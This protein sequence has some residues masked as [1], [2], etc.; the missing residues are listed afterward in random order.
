[1]I[2]EKLL[3]IQQDLK[4]PKDLYNSFGNYS[5]R[6]CESILEALKPLLKANGCVITFSDKMIEVGG[7]NYAE[8]TLK[9]IDAKSG[10]TI[11]VTACAREEETKK[12]MDGSQITGAS[13]SYARKYALGAMF[14]I[15]DNKDSDSTNTGEPQLYDKNKRGKTT[16]AVNDEATEWVDLDKIDEL[17]DWRSMALKL[18]G[19]KGYKDKDLPYYFAVTKDTTGEEWKKIYEDI[20]NNRI[21]LIV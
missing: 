20:L 16:Q 18:W 8:S 10:D 7:R 13:S 15:D 12:G 14:A 21:G 5:H 9:F 3:N 1:M 6:S 19:N 2:Y 17:V 4:A 11:E